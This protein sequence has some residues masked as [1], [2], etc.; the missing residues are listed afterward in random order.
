M[1]SQ[2]K[3]P[4]SPLFSPAGEGRDS[5][6]PPRSAPVSK[7]KPGLDELARAFLMD[8]PIPE[9]PASAAEEPPQDPNAPLPSFP[10]EDEVEVSGERPTAPPP[11]GYD[12]L[13][14][15]SRPADKS[16]GLPAAAVDEVVANLRRD[17]RF[18]DE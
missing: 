13:P 12:E 17:S 11:P 2:R 7:P 4:A 18:D 15:S 14:R 16:R 8:E 5:T 1:A 6:R 9:P 3:V 10:F